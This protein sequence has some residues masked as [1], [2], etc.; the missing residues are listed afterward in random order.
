MTVAALVSA[1]LPGPARAWTAPIPLE[2]TTA[3]TIADP[4]G[5]L[6]VITGGDTFMRWQTF[7]ATGHLGPAQSFPGPAAGTA[8]GLGPVAW[9]PGGRAFVSWGASS[10]G[11]RVAV[12]NAD[13]SWGPNT[14]SRAA[15]AIAARGNEALLWETGGNAVQQVTIAGDGTL[16]LG[17][18]AVL[19]QPGDKYGSCGGAIALDAAGNAVLVYS[20]GLQIRKAARTP[21]G[22]WTVSVLEDAPPG[23]SV[24]CPIGSAQ[25]GRLIAAWARETAPGAGKRSDARVATGTPAGVTVQTLASTTFDADDTVTDPNRSTAIAQAAAGP[26]GSLVAW[27]GTLK[28]AHGATPSGSV[29]L[30][31]A[32]PTGSLGAVTPANTADATHQFNYNLAP[33]GAFGGSG[34]AAT[35]EVHDTGSPSSLCNQGGQGDT[36]DFVGEGVG[37]GDSSPL[38]TFGPAANR[39]YTFTGAAT[40]GAGDGVVTGVLSQ[41]GSSQ[42]AM[43]TTGTPGKVGPG[44]LPPGGTG[45]PPAGAGSGPAGSPGAPGAP[46]TGT[47]AAG[48]HVPTPLPPP[49]KSV[50]VRFAGAH[51][52]AGELDVTVAVPSDASTTVT[53]AILAAAF[54]TPH[55]ARA[56]AAK[57][58]T[59]GKVSKTV[60]KAG[61]LVLKVR[62]S[63][64]GKKLLAKRRT[65]KATVVLTTKTSGRTAVTTKKTLTLRRH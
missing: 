27:A 3:T 60:H 24:G 26:D 1:A 37:I 12:R 53:C 10:Y 4:S 14:L 6:H 44:G 61:K 55:A 28:C 51:A 22:T 17:A 5:G 9:M 46:G 11:G 45:T 21:D 19:T 34:L 25:Q 49:P 38:Y 13:G 30:A 64:A 7:D 59:L 23:G 50:S 40:D 58:V 42:V 63:K 18:R 48:N 43:W 36:S 41:Q 47:P 2:R 31:T 20:A 57:T 16:A 33:L 65:L 56:A 52:A 62:Y 39:F 29:G 54:N 32:T 35:F 8:L 15:T